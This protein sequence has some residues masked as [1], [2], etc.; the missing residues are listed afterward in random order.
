MTYKTQNFKRRRI[1][2]SL[3][4]R[5]DGTIPESSKH[6]IK[7]CMVPSVRA[8]GGKFGLS[9]TASMKQEMLLRAWLG[10]VRGANM[11]NFIH[12]FKATMAAVIF[13][14]S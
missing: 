1:K 11:P 6:I 10:R 8:A 13:N 7:A 14:S 2:T 5:S 9:V 3:P 12:A 4:L